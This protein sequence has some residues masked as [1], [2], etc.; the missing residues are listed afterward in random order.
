MKEDKFLMLFENVADEYILEAN[1]LKPNQLRKKLI[2]YSSL[3]A[4][5]CLVLISTIT[6]RKLYNSYYTETSYVGIDVNPSI[7]LCLNK[8]DRVIETLAYNEDGQK[9]LDH[10]S[11]KHKTYE[12]ALGSMLK[13]SEFEEYLKKSNEISITISSDCS[14]ELKTHIEQCFTTIPN[15]KSICSTDISTRNE[16]YTH[17][18][19][20]KKYMMYQ[21][22]KK[23]D[24]SVTIAD[25][26]N[27]SIHELHKKIDECEYTHSSKKDN[28]IEKPADNSHHTTGHHKH[29]HLE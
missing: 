18:C 5:I 28:F 23:Y 13:N 15:E 27:M 8:Y 22:L 26:N 7:E 4:C 29:S 14:N 10:L 1:P 16:A 2:K 3:A 11:L 24:V 19:S 17:N 25:C 20:T 12:D 21:E 6:G 9:V